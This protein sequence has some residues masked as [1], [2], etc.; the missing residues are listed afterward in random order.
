MTSRAAMLNGGESGPAVVPGNPSESLLI[1]AVHYQDFEM[2][3]KG[4]LPDESIAT[5]EQ[6]IENGAADPR[7]EDAVSTSREIN[8]DEGR[9]F[10]SFQPRK[11]VPPPELNDNQWPRSDIDR[12]VIQRLIA[13]GIQPNP[14]A[15]R[16]VMIRRA[17]MTLIGLA[18]SPEQ[19]DDFV[20]DSRPFEEAFGSV[21]D[22]LLAS[23]HF[24]ERW[25]RHWLDVARFA[26][27][28]GGGR[29]LMFKD[30]WRFRDY[31]IAAYNKDKPF[32]Q[33]IREQ[34]A[35]DL[36]P[37]DSIEQ[38]SEQLTAPGFLALGPINYEQQNKSLLQMEIVDEQVDTVG[39]AFLAMTL[40][41]ARCHD[42][43]FDPIPTADYYAMAGIFDSTQSVVH[44]NVSSYVTQKL[45]LP[46]AE[47]KV[48]DEY[49][50]RISKLTVQE[51]EAKAE[52]DRLGGKSDA[53][54]VKKRVRLKS[55][56]GIV[57]DSGKAKITG[58][59]KS[60]TVV[61]KFVGK[62]YI[63]NEGARPG[64]GSVVYAPRFAKGG[65]YEVRLAY[66]PG[67]NRA[68]NVP[69]TV[70]HQDGQDTILINQSQTPPID[71]L[72]ISLGTFRFEAD[73][74]AS[75]TIG[76]QDT[77]GV[78]IAD[79]V[80]FLSPDEPSLI[81]ADKDRDVVA[82]SNAD[83]KKTKASETSAK[84]AS[85][86]KRLKALDDKLKELKKS[87][88]ASSP[89]AMSVKDAAE[90]GDGHIHIRG[91]FDNLGPIVSRGF[92]SVACE[93]KAATPKIPDGSSGRL[94]LANW[95]A[96]PDNPLTARVYVNRVWRQIFG[97]G[98]VATVDS[99][100]S[101]GEEP[102]HPELLDFLAEQF[103][104]DGWS[105]KRL[106]RRLM[107]SRVYQLSSEASATAMAVDDQNRLLWRANRRRVDAEVLRDTILQASS[108]L[109]LKAGGLTIRK[110]SA[111]DLGYQFKTVRR[112]VYV[113]AFRNSM[114]PFLEVFDVA[115]PNLVTGDRNTTTLATQ[116]LFMMNSPLVIEESRKLADQLLAEDFANETGRIRAVYRRLL[117]RAPTDAELKLAKDYLSEFKPDD[118]K[119]DDRKEAWA[120]FC[121]GLFACVDFR[122]VE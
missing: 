49:A 57:L 7:T 38:R 69:V 64:L 68:S 17:Y 56:N 35:G 73:N 34:I 119:L 52:V 115:N 59:W 118:E 13:E 10:W 22:E 6:W 21:V 43:K 94:E 5:L 12:F 84:L 77:D 76:T 14:D 54:I 80:Q 24:G 41:C 110:L 44:G 114:M 26:E 29:S 45:P 39:R 46:E 111:Y 60:S 103:I 92:L 62:D 20:D 67:G 97:R 19:I 117:G 74:A 79:A 91:S 108:S 11:Q 32:D 109:D 66:S 82:D 89:V 65:K 58:K 88:R 51:R 86:R 37:H 120:S 112:S 25:G 113:P 55:L 105:T 33:F 1:S 72:F 36:L 3:P 98:L 47:Q 61:A 9:K 116:A 107:L 31:V 100:G 122:Y 63:H 95:I 101:M 53:D 4:K 93:P 15:N 87:V 70:L 106:I 27:S 83:T 96:S 90:P 42:H 48:V 30:A 99:F 102:S 23:P 8:I 81:G 104:A 40:G 18:P 71:R 28:S 50:E 16:R 78:V 2:P 85:A 75:V 121:H